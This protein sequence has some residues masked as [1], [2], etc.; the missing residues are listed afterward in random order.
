MGQR[1]WP[2]NRRP[3]VAVVRATSAD[4]MRDKQYTSD[5]PRQNPVTAFLPCDG[6]RKQVAESI[7]SANTEKP[8]D[9]YT[10]TLVAEITTNSQYFYDSLG[11][12]EL[13]NIVPKPENLQIIFK[14]HLL[15]SAMELSHKGVQQF[16]GKK[17]ESHSNF[18]QRQKSVNQKLKLLQLCCASTSQKL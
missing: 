5:A 12:S 18:F 14:W 8:V 4:G 13:G 17:E 9:K 3:G 10:S 2:E 16:C 7:F 15:R 1:A 6:K 11:S